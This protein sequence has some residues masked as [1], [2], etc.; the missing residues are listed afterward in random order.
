M[1]AS[2]NPMDSPSAFGNEGDVG[3]RGHGNPD[4]GSA[5]G[6]PELG[7][8]MDVDD[9]AVLLERDVGVVGVDVAG[10][11]GVSAHV[12]ATVGSVE[13][14]GAEGALKGLGGDI[15]LDGAGWRGG[16]QEDAGQEVE[17]GRRLH[18]FKDKVCGDNLEF[19]TPI[20]LESLGFLSVHVR[21]LV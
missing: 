1:R 7:A 12:V 17:Q 14:L 13:E 8:G 10:G 18:G 5:D 6:S 9:D 20:L 19:A 11:V 2:R 16:Q 21:L 3:I 15:H 4:A